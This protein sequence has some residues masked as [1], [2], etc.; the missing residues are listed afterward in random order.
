MTDSFAIPVRVYYE[1][2]DAGGI[3]YHV[4]YLKFMERARTEYLRS[5]GYDHQKLLKEKKQLVVVDA[6]VQ[7]KQI[8]QLDDS[9][10]VTAQV[11]SMGK[12]RMTFLQKV[13]REDV[14]LCEGRF[15]VACLDSET[16]KPTAITE[17]LRNKLSP[18]T[19]SS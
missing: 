12:A 18:D 15:V 14:L 8:A 17:S 19:N 6:S 11:E 2:T 9:L 3:V 5:T 1:D 10:T 4:N 7:F 13:W 16:R